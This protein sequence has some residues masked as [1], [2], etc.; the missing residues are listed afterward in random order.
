MPESSRLLFKATYD[1]I[2]LLFLFRLISEASWS[3][4]ELY[5]LE[6]TGDLANFSWDLLEM[7]DDADD[8]SESKASDDNELGDEDDEK[9][10]LL[11]LL[12]LAEQPDRF[13]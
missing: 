8:D 7:D 3:W 4:L 1:K 5:P 12:L 9:S 6:V 10:S 11:M 13:K 2:L